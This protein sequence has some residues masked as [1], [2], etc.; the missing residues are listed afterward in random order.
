M[1]GKGTAG[2][3]QEVSWNAVTIAVT[4]ISFPRTFDEVDT[5]EVG[6]ATEAA[7]LTVLRV[8]LDLTGIYRPGNAAGQD[9]GQEDLED[10]FLARTSRQ[11]IF[12]PEGNSSGNVQYTITS[13]HCNTFNIDQNG[14]A[15]AVGFS[16]S[17]RTNDGSDITKGTVP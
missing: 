12:Y 17:L 6:D 4:D 8:G 10:D 2:Y 9:P 3:N 15:G 5:T 14:P 16:A 7:L 1:A 13:M 11:V